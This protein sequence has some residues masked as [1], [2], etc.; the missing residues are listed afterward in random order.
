[1]SLILFQKEKHLLS[2]PA[3]FRSSPLPPSRRS[4]RQRNTPQGDDR[5][6]LRKSKTQVGQLGIRPGQHARCSRNR[7][8]YTVHGTCFGRFANTNLAA[9]LRRFV[10]KLLAKKLLLIL[11]DIRN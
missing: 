9:D 1:M 7:T 6:V 3:S 10:I 5:P 8:Q 11:I 4:K 2:R